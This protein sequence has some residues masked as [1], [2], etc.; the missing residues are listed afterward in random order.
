MLWNIVIYD[1][2]MIIFSCHSRSQEQIVKCWDSKGL[3]VM[4]TD[5]RILMSGGRWYFKLLVKS[6]EY[7][8]TVSCDLCIVSLPGVECYT[9][10]WEYMTLIRTICCT[11]DSRVSSPSMYFRMKS[12]IYINLRTSSLHILVE[13]VARKIW[14]TT[15][16]LFLMIS[17]FCPHFL[18]ILPIGN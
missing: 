7:W 3:H 13:C 6:C 14:G 16:K 17:Q 1:Q 11:S 18:F 4:C 15:G 9:R 5:V 8:Q 12:S 2:N 10:S